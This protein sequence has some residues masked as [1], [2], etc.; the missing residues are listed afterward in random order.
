MKSVKTLDDELDLLKE[1]TSPLPILNMQAAAALPF[2]DRLEAS[3]AVEALLPLLAHD[4]P[5][6]R[7]VAAWA[8]GSLGPA[9]TLAVPPLTKLLTD[10]QCNVD[11]FAIDALKRIAS[12]TILDSMAPRSVCGLSMSARLAQAR[13]DNAQSRRV[14]MIVPISLVALRSWNFN[15]RV[16]ALRTLTVLEEGAHLLLP[17]TGLSLFDPHRLVR[18]SAI[19]TIRRI[20]LPE[21]VIRAR[22]IAMGHDPDQLV[23]QM[24]AN[25][26]KEPK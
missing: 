10:S 12:D 14:D 24:I 22:I 11:C 20:G 17:T 5:G 1:L 13:V 25:T 6:L 3:Q 8:L 15:E 4:S 19:M 9:A 16:Q 26:M 7:A 2:S 18:L 23:R 21:H